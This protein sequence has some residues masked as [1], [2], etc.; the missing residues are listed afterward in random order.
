[1]K[2][3][4]SWLKDH[5]ETDATLEQIAEALTAVGL[6][7]EGIEDPAAKYAPFKV[8][9]VESAARHPDAD[10]LQV[11]RV[12]TE[13][14]SL[15]VVCGAPNA[16]ADMK[17]IFA[18]VGAI[19]PGLENMEL[20]KGVIRGVE[21]CGMMASE[22][23]LELS[24]EHKGIIEVDA[25]WDIGTPMAE[26]FGLNDPVIEINVTPNR[27]DCTGVRGIA[28]DLAAAGLGTLKNI[29]DSAVHGHTKSP[30]SVSIED[31]AGCPQFLGRYIKGVKN[32][33][34]PDWLQRRL[35]AIGMNPKSA[36]VDITNYVSYDLGRP[37]HVFD[38]SKLSGNI[39]VRA[40]KDGEKFTALDEEEYTLKDG[41]TLVCDE[42]AVHAIGGVMGGLHSGCSLDTTD[43][44][45]EIAYFDPARI[46]RTGRDTGIVSDARYRFER[47]VDP[48]FLPAAT[49]IATRMILDLCGGEAS[50][51]VH[52][53]TEPSWQRMI[54]YD[55]AYC[56]KLTG[57]A[58]D[59]K[60]QTRI[61]ESLGFAIAG[62]GDKW[63]VQPPSWRGD[64]D[65][66]ADIVEEVARIVGYDKL[67]A[68]SVTKPFAITQPA[69][70]T[71][72]TRA[73][74]ARAA[75]AA[76]GMN[77]CV[78]WS[79]MREDWAEMFGANDYQAA[80]TLK[81][82]NPISAE[83][84]QMRPTPLP[85]LI[86]AAGRCAARG[87][88]ESALFEVG[89]AFHTA[90]P[91]GQVLIAAGVRKG[92]KGPRHWSGAEASRPADAFDAKA[93]ALAALETAG[94]PAA[95]LQVTRDAPDWYH[96]GRSGAL[97]LG[98]NVLAQFGEIHPAL[99]EE[100]GVK[101][102]VVGFEIF[103]DNI[104]ET[105]KSGKARKLLDL[106]SFQPVNRD[107]A[108]IVDEA[109]E[110]GDLI[111]AA[112]AADKKLIAAIEVFDVYQGKGVDEGKKSVA[113]NVT[114]QPVD[115]T[116]TE[117]DID[118]V[119]KK[120]IDAVAAKTGGVLRG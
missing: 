41:M 59:D 21:S 64:V 42:K 9:Y 112:S 47:G 70:T 20:K 2:F 15:Q 3:T 99:L 5:L 95:N 97:R 62:I 43:V 8:A 89:P 12:K 54:D 17:G 1:M 113:L 109:I 68:T 120:I 74:Q 91:D 46:A 90:K 105:R 101:G 34:S 88:P 33:P 13:N 119:S 92:A 6:E 32:A 56:E 98:K 65:G 36:L 110:A 82:K 22:R 48:A 72:R 45:L 77:E 102:P 86:E 96:P 81:I 60:E 35:K 67:P 100:M 39:T 69:E 76:R 28:R 85:N 37:L 4:L 26:V 44:F 11:L 30:I 19:I 58:V 75:L 7:V 78:T 38:V 51:V 104:P 118:G 23:E 40:A 14:E 103:L 66:K 84:S 16:R 29:D 107:F 79:F 63:E 114:L 106:S 49:E 116:L 94:A 80:K 108:F 27:A 73:R 55:P 71:A 18:P 10:R 93:D 83:L 57:I 53:G 111:R 24:D 25:K 50:E 115:A 31:T 52:A 61:L 117:D 87:Y